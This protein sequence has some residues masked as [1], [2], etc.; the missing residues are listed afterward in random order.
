MH[1][2]D[3]GA[4]SSSQD[5]PRDTIVMDGISL[6]PAHRHPPISPRSPLPHATTLR[7]R[8]RDLSPGGIN[9]SVSPHSAPPS[10]HKNALL[11]SNNSASTLPVG[12]AL[13]ASRSNSPAR[14]PR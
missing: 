4:Y 14:P 8:R 1:G 13:N 9:N 6:S 11:M 5:S 7:A 10:P 2:V 3:D 12:S